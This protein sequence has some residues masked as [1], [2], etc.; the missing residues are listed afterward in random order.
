M[1]DWVRGVNRL[2]DLLTRVFP[3]LERAFDYSN[4]A[5]LVLVVG[6]CT[7][8]VIREAGTQGLAE[9]LHT[10]RDPCWMRI[11]S[12]SPAVTWRPSAAPP[13]WPPMPA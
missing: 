7:L 3:G 5:P 13:G 9:R 11:S 1:A 12:R 8:A 4:R 6:Y 10:G 2:R